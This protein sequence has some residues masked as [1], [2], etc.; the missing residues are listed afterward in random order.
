MIT[1]SAAS[2]KCSSRKRLVQS[3]KASSAPYIPMKARSSSASTEPVLASRSELKMVEKNMPNDR[4]KWP[5]PSTS[6]QK[7]PV[8]KYRYA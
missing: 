3:M 4:P 5:S 8:R 1:N 6:A 2:R 7:F